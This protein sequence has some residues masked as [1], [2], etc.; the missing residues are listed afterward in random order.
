MTKKEETKKELNIDEIM[1]KQA[2]GFLE[3]YR[4]LVEEYGFSLGATAG[5]TADGRIAAQINVVVSTDGRFQYPL[6]RK[7]AG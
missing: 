2:Q 5:L 7:Q 1:S 4:A 3:A 6:G